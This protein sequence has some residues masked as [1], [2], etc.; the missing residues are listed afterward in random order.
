MLTRNRTL[1]LLL[2]AYIFNFVDRNII[3]VL[4]VPIRTEFSLSDTALGSLGVAFG[5]VYAAAAVPVAWLA[6]RRGRAG[7]I[8]AAVTV[9]SLFTAACG[10]VHSYA[11][12]IAAR[13]GVA[14]GEAGGIAPSYALISSHYPQSQRARAL[15]IFSFGVPI[16]SALGI[17]FGGALAASLSWRLAFVVVGLAGLP[18]ALL[19][20]L[21]VRDARP[22]EAPPSAT[23]ALGALAQTP[24]FWLL[25]LAAAAGSIPG[26]GLIFWLP[27]FFN[28]SFALPIDQVGW[29]YGSIVLVGGLAGTWAGGWV[30]DRAGP[31]RPAAYALIPAFCFLTAVPLFALGMFAQSLPLAWLLFA[32]A[33]M[34]SLAWLGPVVSAVQMIVAP[35]LRATASATFLFINNLVGIAGG[36]FAL[37]WLSDA[38]KAAR[39]VD[40]LRYSIL[41]ALGFY[42]LSALIYLLAARR[43]SG[44]LKMNDREN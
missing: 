36:T 1:L 25:S 29:F 7:I 17:M 11:H 5:I 30:G 24:S 42:L 20:G 22:A 39:G 14:V 33:Q 31:S 12:L 21:F 32:I 40:S 37:G 18:V 27:S 3:G 28:R 34:L 9:W 8:A 26:Y 13:M 44:D 38:M 6:D 10:L 16:G 41:Y 15:A 23:K 43:L 35:Q 4:A 2:L 19:I